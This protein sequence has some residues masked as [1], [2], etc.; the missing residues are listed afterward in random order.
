ML[1]FHSW[2]RAASQEDKT[3][4][5]WHCATSRRRAASM[6]AY[7]G[8]VHDH[9]GVLVPTPMT[10]HVLINPNDAH[11]FKASRIREQEFVAIGQYRLVGSMPGYRQVSGDLVHGHVVSD[12]AHKPPAQGPEGERGAW[13]SRLADVI[14]PGTRTRAT[15]VP[16]HI[17]HQRRGLMPRGSC[18]KR[19]VHDPSEYPGHPHPRH[20]RTG[21]AARHFK[22][23]PPPWQHIPTA[24]KPSSSGPVRKLLTVC[25]CGCCPGRL[26]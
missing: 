19:R 3:R 22:A 16:S 1:S 25:L 10:S 2:G 14:T 6:V 13:G 4:V 9:R 17:H 12:Q 15:V 24:T 23:N 21:L 20:S 7:R 18:A 8:Q 5:E 11:A 26:V